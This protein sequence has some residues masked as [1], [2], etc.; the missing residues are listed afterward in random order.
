V[1][2]C[3][4]PRARYGQS[5]KLSASLLLTVWAKWAHVTHA[6]Y[7]TVQQLKCWIHNYTD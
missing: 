3:V 4:S 5:Q 6:E 7:S 1:C 2:V